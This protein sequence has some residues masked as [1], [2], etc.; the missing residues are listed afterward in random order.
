MMPAV[1]GTAAED[2]LDEAGSEAL[3]GLWETVKKQNGRRVDGERS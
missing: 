1:V 3:Q 2:W